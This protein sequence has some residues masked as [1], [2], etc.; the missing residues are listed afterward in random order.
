MVDPRAI[1]RTRKRLAFDSLL[2]HVLRPRAMQ[3]PDARK[4]NGD[5]TVADAVLSG[6]AMFSLKDPSLLAFDKRRAKPGNLRQVFGIHKLV[7]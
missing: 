6:L 2:R 5:Y 1:P 3:L 7:K 4:R